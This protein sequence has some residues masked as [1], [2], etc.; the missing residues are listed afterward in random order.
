MKNIGISNVQFSNSKYNSMLTSPVK[1][2]VINSLSINMYL[3]IISTVSIKIY[4]TYV[5]NLNLTDDTQ[6]QEPL[7][8]ES[9]SLSDFPNSDSADPLGDGNGSALCS[10]FTSKNDCDYAHISKGY[11]KLIIPIRKL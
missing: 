5:L 2:H 7:L 9:S 6:S 10:I 1:Y 11:L 3:T 4:L 8:N